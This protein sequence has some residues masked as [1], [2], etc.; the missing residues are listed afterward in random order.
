MASNHLM[1]CCPLL[2]LHSIFLSIRVF[3]NESVLRIR[4]PKYWSFS[5]SI[6]PS[7][8]YRIDFLWFDLLAVQRT[9]KSL[10]Q[11]HYLKVSILRLSA[12]FMVQ[13][14]HSYMTTGKTIALTI[15]T[16]V[17]KLISLLFSMLSRFIIALLPRRRHFK[18]FWLQSPSTVILEPK[19]RKYATVSTFFPTICHEVMEPD[20]MILVSLCF[21]VSN[22]HFYFPLSP[23]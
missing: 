17:V 21:W 11:H 4:W 22:Q 7:N 23:S 1:L 18:I 5:F 8:E 20:T 2:L 6:I 15:W 3:S 14:S 10:L 19:K 16:F 9:L 13:H 12:F